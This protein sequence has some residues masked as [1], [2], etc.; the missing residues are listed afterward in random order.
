M[1]FD[2]EKNDLLVA[3]VF[4]K[5]HKHARIRTYVSAVTHERDNAPGLF[6]SA[7]KEN[8]YCTLCHKSEGV[9]H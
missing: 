6:H 3:H 1:R 4:I 9:G 2:M 7:R 5:N 8:Q